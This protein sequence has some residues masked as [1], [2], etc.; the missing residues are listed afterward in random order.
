MTEQMTLIQGYLDGRLTSEQVRALQTW[1]QANTDNAQVFARYCL[2]HSYLRESFIEKD[3]QTSLDHSGMA[4]TNPMDTGVVSSEL[5]LEPF[6]TEQDKLNDIK[7]HAEHQLQVFLAEQEKLK[8]TPKS[9][10]SSS[11]DWTKAGRKIRIFVSLFA[12]IAAGFVIFVGIVLIVM[13]M[14]GALRPKPE[15]VATITES[16]Q[17]QWAETP[18]QL[19]LYPGSMTLEEGFV[20]LDFKNGAKVVLQ[21]PAKIHLETASQMVLNKG[22]LVARAEKGAVGFTVRTPGS[23]IVD[24]G[25]EFGVLVTRQKRSEA[26]VFEGEVDLRSGSNPK[27]YKASR[28][29]VVNE[30]CSANLNGDLSPV[31]QAKSSAFKR[32]VPS[33]YE[34]AVLASRPMA[35]WRFDINSPTVLL[36]AHNSK[37]NSGRY[38]GPVQF[39]E[40][41]DLGEGKKAMALL[42][43]GQQSYGLIE[44]MTVPHGEYTTGYTHV[45]WIC[46]DV[47]REQSILNTNHSDKTGGIRVLTMTSEG[48]FKH[49]LLSKDSST[50][51]SVISKTVALPGQWYH[52]VVLRSTFDD[53]KIFVN[54][55]EEDVA[56][57]SS[58]GTPRFQDVAY[59]GTATHETTADKLPLFKGALSEVVLYNRALTAE[60]ISRLY[61]AAT[62]RE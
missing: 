39:T 45:A 56:E 51:A 25:T 16:V 60:E 49:G 18:K 42:C 15:V 44:G 6:D 58:S 4:N 13:A 7:R 30:S 3:L 46:A 10:R 36:N 37:V 21:A 2:L 48:R 31:R 57:L 59:L 8:P 27:K 53:R 55:V 52:I 43:D 35:Y 23:S 34:L 33:A 32:Y 12:K 41:P 61:Q 14:F 24:F 9:V 38:A 1:I 50:V 40:G 26:H 47:I 17:A 62:Y 22:R 28:R 20:Q 29:L 19:E 11:L 54:G 5:M